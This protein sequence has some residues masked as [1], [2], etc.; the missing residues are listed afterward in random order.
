M[1][2]RNVGVRL[3]EETIKKLEEKGKASTVIRELIIESFN[4]KPPK[5]VERVRIK[6]IIKEI[7]V[8][9]IKMVAVNDASKWRNLN[10]NIFR[11]VIKEEIQEGKMPL[12]YL[13]S[14]QNWFK[15]E[16]EEEL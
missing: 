9:I 5:I 16:F 13:A 8:E 1:P 4:P 12:W 6:E 15:K 14:R 2:K 10:K 7:P 3:D 11:E